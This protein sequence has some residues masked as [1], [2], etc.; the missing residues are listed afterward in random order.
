MRTIRIN[1]LHVVT[2]IAVEFISIA[3]ASIFALA[4]LPILFY[5]LAVLILACLVR[6]KKLGRP[7]RLL[8]SIPY[9]AIIVLSLNGLSILWLFLFHASKP[10]FFLYILLVCLSGL[11][12]L[13][14]KILGLRWYHGLLFSAVFILAFLSFCLSQ[15]SLS[16]K[17]IASRAPYGG[18]EM[19]I[20]YR[21]IFWNMKGSAPRYLELDPEEKALFI[22]NRL[23]A[24]HTYA[25]LLVYD[26]EKRAIHI[27]DLSGLPAMGIKFDQF[28]N[29][30][31]VIAYREATA[32]D[33]KHG[34]EASLFWVN[35]AGEAVNRVPIHQRLSIYC[36]LRVTESEVDVLYHDFL[37]TYNR[38]TFVTSK[39]RIPIPTVM[40]GM[41]NFLAFQDKTVLCTGG[42]VLSMFLTPGLYLLDQQMTHVITSRRLLGGT[43]VLD[44][45]S[46]KGEIYTNAQWS[47]TLR[48]YDRDLNLLRKVKVGKVIRA[49]AIDSERR[50]GYAAEYV[51][52]DIIAFSLDT[53]EKLGSVNVGKGARALK[54]AKNGDLFAGSLNG[55]FL[56][57]LSAWEQPSVKKPH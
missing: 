32:K 50:V 41:T 43:Y 38:K 39:R 22:C 57:P 34:R 33:T 35:R 44:Y 53:G 1:L 47:G 7:L 21:V 29:S 37:L 3:F 48:V 16:R 27:V 23:N 13:K 46:K 10:L 17:P 42:P 49:I 54:L 4:G 26:I 45:D 2:P 18:A 19:V 12:L 52:G 24:P 6:I 20:D 8:F 5:L 30:L 9:G 25:S 40:T 31:A 28:T 55:I 15:I 14:V 51:D 36:F 56:I 11:V